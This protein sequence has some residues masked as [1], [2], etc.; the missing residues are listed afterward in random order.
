M[1]RESFARVA[2]CSLNCQPPPLR[3]S[4]PRNSTQL[5]TPPPPSLMQRCRWISSCAISAVATAI[6]NHMQRPLISF[7]DWTCLS[8]DSDGVALI[9]HGFGQ[10]QQAIMLFSFVRRRGG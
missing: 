7:F 2:G 5:L 6:H 1:L 8:P 10:R 9:V 3:P 4:V